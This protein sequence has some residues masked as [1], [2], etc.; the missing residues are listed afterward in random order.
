MPNNEQIKYFVQR[1]LGCR[2]PAEVFCSIECKQDVRLSKDIVLTSMITIGNRLLIY[3][4]GAGPNGFTKS[5]LALLVSAGKQGRDSRGLNR[6]RLVIVTDEAENQLP[7]QSA[8][9]E[10]KG[11]DEKIHL[12][13]ISKEQN[14]FSK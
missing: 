2:C 1:I 5:N 13:I 11:V 8:F 14:I 9:D 6:M 10:L 12:H 4:I 7:L 3:V